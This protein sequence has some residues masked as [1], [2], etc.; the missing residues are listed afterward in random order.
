[1][2]WPDLDEVVRK[3]DQPS[4]RFNDARQIWSGAIAA[5][6]SA[7][8]ALRVDPGTLGPMQV[9]AVWRF[10]TRTAV[11]ADDMA[12]A[13]LALMRVARRIALID[14]FG[15]EL[16]KDEVDDQVIVPWEVFGPQVLADRGA[17]DETGVAAWVSS[18]TPAAWEFGY[19]VGEGRYPWIQV[20]ALQIT[21]E[22]LRR[23]NAG[24]V[25]VWPVEP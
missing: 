12:R 2:T 25:T 8:A 24:A 9:S 16:G 5:A 21:L 18:R 19:E 4:V 11:A 13:E 23:V 14:E 1:M 10:C 15:E 7:D 6:V 20:R 17:R 3:L 22:E